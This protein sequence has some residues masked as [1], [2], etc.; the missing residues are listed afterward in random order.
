MEKKPG[1]S[2]VNRTSM[3]ITAAIIA[4]GLVIVLTAIFI[5]PL[6]SSTPDVGKHRTVTDMAGNTVEIPTDINRIVITCCG[7]ATHEV[8]V[9]GVSDR[10]VAQPAKCIMPQLK[11][12]KPGF[13][14]VTD[15]GSFDEVNIEQIVDLHP[16][17]VIAAVTSEK[18][19]TKIR[20]AGIPVI[21]VMVG[22]GNISQLKREFT[23][24]GNLLGDEQQAVSLNTYWDTKLALVKERVAGIP[25]EQKKRVYYMLGKTT[26]TNGGGWWG[27]EFIT[28]AGGINVAEELGT[29]RDT[30][31][32]QLVKWN[33]DVIILSSNEGTFM[34]VGDVKNN[35]QLASIE[36]VRN[37]RIY[38]CPIGSFWWDRP[39]PEAPLG[40]LWLAKTI[41]PEKFADIDLKAETQ[42]FYRTYYRYELSDQE[43]EKFLNPQPAT[44]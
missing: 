31:V 5:M 32:E 14:T 44:K 24:M 36:A 35:D 30:S 13:S 7:G 15:A 29:I 41:Y 33:P 40:I 10:I 8:M 20:E 3:K 9:M 27:Q 26:H 43:Y 6:V 39:S 16:D 42:D 22:R 37:N 1:Q 38:E 11:V 25:T 34:P 18:G 21:T 23:M 4:A 17:V 12:M 28:A 2:K 19:N